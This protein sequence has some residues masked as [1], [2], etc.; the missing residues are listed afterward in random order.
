MDVDSSA[1][2]DPRRS[3]RGDRPPFPSRSSHHEAQ[4]PPP[5]VPAQ[6]SVFDAQNDTSGDQFVRGLS[7][8]IHTAVSAITT[9]AERE[10][11]QKKRGSIDDLLR[12]AEVHK[13][14]PSTIDFFQNVRDEEDAILAKVDRK[15]K[16]HEAN[17]ER[18]QADLKTHWASSQNSQS[19]R[20]DE[21]VSEL[22]QDNRWAKDKVSHMQGDIEGLTSRHKSLDIDIKGLQEMLNNQQKGFASYTNSIGL[23]SKD[24]NDYSTRLE[25]VEKGV[26]QPDQG[27]SAADT[28]NLNAKEALGDVVDQYK[29]LEQKV[30]VL[31]EKIDF[32]FSSYEKSSALPDHLNR[33]LKDQ[34]E[35][36]DRPV[37]DQATISRLNATVLKLN[38]EF[39][40]LQSIQSAKD[41]LQLA[42]LEDLENKLS[43]IKKDYDRLS[44]NMDQ[45]SLSVPI[46][47]V[48]P[49]FTQIAADV[50]RLQEGMERLHEGVQNAGVGL[51]SLESRYNNLS[52][53]PI[54]QH[55][56]GAFQE[57]YPQF[58]PAHK[59]L[60]RKVEQLETQAR[61]S[62]VSQDELKKDQA[63]M[64]LRLGEVLERYQWLSREEFQAVQSRLEILS[65]RQSNMDRESDSKKTSDQSFLQEVERERELLNNRMASLSQE[66]ENLKSECKQAQDNVNHNKDEMRSLELRIATHEESTTQSYQKFKEQLDTLAKPIP[67]RE[68]FP[69]NGSSTR[70]HTP[71]IQ[72]SRRTRPD[73]LDSS[74]GTKP[75]RRRPSTCSE[76]ENF[77]RPKSNSPLSQDSI[78]SPTVAPGEVRKK[79]KK[80][81]KLEAE[82]PIEIDD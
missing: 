44:G 76:D 42:G 34:Q 35:K 31:G 50:R 52:T 75:K 64:S 45:L 78:A 71:K 33:N 19:S 62:T 40:E 74:T 51:Q 14:F 77:P 5:S 20:L 72:A 46:H 22:Q 30:A 38:N 11:V 16:E 79:K 6:Q 9:K 57:I 69:E 15:L 59:M 39:K 65:E 54:V 4:Q 55:M 81:R 48:E 21:V 56:L 13:A 58:D 41:E 53:E 67:P 7:G 47:P 73:P 25:Q 8:L 63:T 43:L 24:L 10:K 12:K 82:A 80:K 36:L 66:V 68:L 2:R 29:Q 37:N 3:I 60:A 23:I 28:R 61:T 32:F 26:I 18:F 70:E 17:Y 1:S 27:S 49:R